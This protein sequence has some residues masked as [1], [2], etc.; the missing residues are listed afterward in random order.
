MDLNVG[1][2]L[3]DGQEGGDE[4]DT[5]SLMWASTGTHSQYSGNGSFYH[6]NLELVSG[7]GLSEIEEE[8]GLISDTA[9]NFSNNSRN[10]QMPEKDFIKHISIQRENSYIGDDDNNHRSVSQTSDQMNFKIWISIPLQCQ[11]Q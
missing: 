7:N 10:F 2:I 3:E 1:S 9:S 4:E 8:S 5:K 6:S 11:L